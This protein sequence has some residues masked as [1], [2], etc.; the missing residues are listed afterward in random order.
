MSSLGERFRVAREARGLTLSEVAEHI[1]IRSVYLGAIEDE[2][3]DVIGA[4]V[5]ARGFVRTYAR[6]LGIDGEE[7]ISTSILAQSI[8]SSAPPPE[9]EPSVS[10]SG[11][12]ASSSWILWFAGIVAAVLIGLIVYNFVALR[13]EPSASSVAE[14]T[15][16]PSALPSVT[17]SIAPLVAPS[18]QPNATGSP[19]PSV[20]PTPGA[21]PSP[22]PTPAPGSGSLGVI[23]R[24]TSW[25]RVVMDGKTVL[26]G[27]FP[28]GTTRVLYGKKAVVRIGNAG[29]VE[30]DVNGASIGSLGKDG[31][32]VDRTIPL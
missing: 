16:T 2:K 12:R 24:A 21:S 20:S 10:A 26:E 19:L 18:A 9:D 14:A 29:G 30:L 5:Y 4:P 11:R 28:A 32:V 8:P 22:S 31:V 6:F 1:R 27:T 3:W 7:A 15:S 13:A 17:P 23:V 25:I